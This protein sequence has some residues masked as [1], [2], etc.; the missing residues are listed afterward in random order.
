[1]KWK[2]IF[3]LLEVLYAG[4]AGIGAGYVF[5]RSFD[6]DGFTRDVLGFTVFFLTV[7]G[8]AVWF[9]L[10]NGAS[11]SQICDAATSGRQS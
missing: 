6:L 9:D 8:T 11:I 10:T 7:V 4:F 2:A 3:V 5:G 1:M